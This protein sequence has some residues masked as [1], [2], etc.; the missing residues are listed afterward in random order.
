MATRLTRLTLDGFKSIRRLDE[1]KPGS[2]TVLIGANGAGKSNLISFFR[3]L[4]YMMSS[5]SGLQAHLMQTGRAHSW[6]HD[7]PAVTSAI[8][9]GLQIETD[10]GSNEYEFGLEYAAGDRL[11]F[12]RELFRF[13]PKAVKA[14]PKTSLGTGHEESRLRERAERGDP[15]PAAICSMLRRF[16]IHQFHN[17]SFTSRM[18]QAWE[19][20]EGR[21]LK[22]DAGNLGAFL[23]RLKSQES[24]A[25]YYARIVQTIRQSLPFFA[26]FELEPANGQVILAWREVNSDQ[27]F[28]AHQAAD[29]MLRFMALVALLLQPADD[30]PELLIL[31]EPELGLH[32]HA[33]TTIA[34]LIQSV[35][36]EKQ[37]IL[38]TQS[39]TLLNEFKP[40]D[41]V[42]VERRG[43][44]S[45]FRRLDSKQL[46]AWLEQYTMGELWEK[47][48]F[49]GRPTWQ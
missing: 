22:E 18:R 39:V 23:Y 42:V 25:P 4:C 19:I 31:D 48:V 35:S 29:G 40:E 20:S 12:S 10:R 13:V 36:L 43:R 44:E 11:Y 38:A 15:T 46:A 24:L 28:E 41:V 47:N 1:L 34:G 9:A 16:I 6:L 32:P 14:N 8:N 7:G 17:T 45:T 2:L 33:I 30:L 21:W 27:I 3:A 26:D 37:V 49:G 5:P